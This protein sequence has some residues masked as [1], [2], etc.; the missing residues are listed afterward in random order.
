MC[1][2]WIAIFCFVNNVLFCTGKWTKSNFSPL[3]HHRLSVI[4][5][6]IW[7][8]DETTVS[9]CYCRNWGSLLAFGSQKLWEQW[10]IEENSGRQRIQL[11]G[12]HL[13]LSDV[14]GHRHPVTHHA[15]V[16]RE[17][18]ACNQCNLFWQSLPS[19]HCRTF[20]S[21]VLEKLRTMKRSWRTSIEN[22]SMPMKRSAIV[23]RAVGILMFVTKTTPG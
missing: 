19:W 5:S 7:I 4:L 6:S 20:L 12:M 15:S 17:Q 22:T 23:W 2:T 16:T 11:H 8:F 13:S 10:R 9:L 1:Y 21:Y 14:P 18:P 3:V